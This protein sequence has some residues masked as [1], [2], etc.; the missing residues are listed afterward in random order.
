VTC[1]RQLAHDPLGLV[2][3]NF[4]LLVGARLSPSADPCQ[5]TDWCLVPV[6]KLSIKWHD[7]QWITPAPF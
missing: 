4:L 1:L 3:V 2:A 7:S 5:R 6:D